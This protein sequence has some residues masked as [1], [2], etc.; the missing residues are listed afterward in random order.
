MMARQGAACRVS[1]ASIAW[2]THLRVANVARLFSLTQTLVLHVP[3]CRERERE[4]RKDGDG[5]GDRE[6]DT[7]K[8][9]R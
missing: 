3:Y 7:E 9:G 2:T 8:E 4:R 6:G 1:E 5:D